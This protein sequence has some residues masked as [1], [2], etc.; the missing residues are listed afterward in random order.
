MPNKPFKSLLKFT[1]VTLMG[2]VLS[3]SPAFAKEKITVFAAAS[4]NNALT[5]IAREYDKAHDT[6]TV[7]S[8]ASSSTLAR[9]IAEGAPA[10]I[11]LSANQKW[12]NYLVDEKV[13]NAANRVT[14][15]KNT[16]VLIAPKSSPIE[17]VPLTPDWDIKTSLDN[18]RLAVGDPDHVPAG[19]YAMEALKSL[20]LWQQAEPLLARANNVRGALALVERG[21]SQ[22]GIVYGTDAKVAANVKV[23]ATF[24]A[25]SHDPIEYPMALVTPQNSQAKAFYDYLQAKQARA[26]FERYGFQVS[27]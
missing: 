17:H 12:M 21:E 22:L 15:L 5:D 27:H 4:L 18:T 7:L 23:V 26:V 9:Q 19:R 11:Y 10:D 24:P 25:A 16:L 1:S 6:E 3:M 14:L 13:V 20:G 2:L 8:F